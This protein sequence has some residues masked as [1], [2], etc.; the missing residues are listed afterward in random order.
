[1]NNFQKILFGLLTIGTITIL[2]NA[3]WGQIENRELVR[4]R[5]AIEELNNNYYNTACGHR[6]QRPSN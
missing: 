2:T 5:I 3:T 6:V 1:M 4:I